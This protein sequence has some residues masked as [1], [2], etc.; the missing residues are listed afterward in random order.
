MSNVDVTG[1]TIKLNKD[2]SFKNVESRAGDTTPATIKP[3]FG[4]G[5]GAR[6]ITFK[7]NDHVIRDFVIEGDCKLNSLFGGMVGG[8]ISNLTII[9]AKVMGMNDADARA[10]IVVAQTFGSVKF[11]SVT[12]KDSYLEGTQKVGG[13]LAFVQENQVEVSNCTVDGLELNSIDHAE[14]GSTGGLIGCINQGY[15]KIT[16]SIVKNSTFNLI[17]KSNEDI[18]KRANGEFIGMIRGTST[19][20]EITNCGVE[21]NNYTNSIAWEPFHPQFVGGNYN[22]E[23]TLIV[24]G[25]IYPEVLPDYIEHDNYLEVYT[26]KGL[27]KWAYRVNAGENTLGLQLMHDI[28]M[29]AFTIE[30]DAVN[31][32]YKFTETAITVDD[33]GVPSGS[34]WIPVRSYEDANGLYYAGD[35]EGNNK[36]ISGLRI[37]YSKY[38][39]GFIGFLKPDAE[40]KNFTLND[41]RI[42]STSE[43]TGAVVGY[44]QDGNVID[45]I[46]VTN[47]SIKGTSNVGGIVGFTQNRNVKSDGTVLNEEISIIKNCMIDN[48]SS[49]VGTDIYIGGI[50]GSSIGAIIINCI[51]NADIKGDKYVG[52]IVGFTRTYNQGRS[53]YL[54]ASGS[55]VDA[56]ITA[57]NHAGGIAG[58]T[59]DDPNHGDAESYIIA[60]YS[61]STISAAKSGSMIGNNYSGCGISASWAKKNDMTNYSGGSNFITTASKHY[62]DASEI[63]QADIDAMNAAIDAYNSISGIEQQCPYTWSWT[64]GSWPVLK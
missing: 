12:V 14:S 40:I 28:E 27:L 62:N 7:G 35:I 51:N 6:N 2:L 47:S 22:E 31:A 26:A 23:A 18:A 50:C 52:G 54:I 56:T 13:L 58:S 21:N 60:C 11:E 46:I 44:C 41:A 30:E 59:W 20:V 25:S 39:A 34:N 45:D 9:N 42:Y 38:T 8:S 49:V 3:L 36:T 29:P 32:T 55:G 37:N 33:N 17:Q 57:N 5:T 19:T 16:N 1:K 4:E 43:Y 15:N 61:L 63:T 64:S 53:G 48:S 24:N 10:A